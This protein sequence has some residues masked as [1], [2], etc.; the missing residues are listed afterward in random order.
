MTAEALN[1]ST[2]LNTRGLPSQ[3]RDAGVLQDQYAWDANGNVASI[4]DQQEGLTS[5]SMGYD[6]LDRLTSASGIWGTGSYG[7]DALDN[8]R[9]STVG[10]RTAVA[11]L[12]SANRLA[13]LTV[14]GVAQSYGYDANGN[15][16]ARGSQA[17]S[18]DIGNRLSSAP[19]KASYA[20]DGHGRRTWVAY[21]DGSWKLQVYGS[22]GRLLFTGHSSQGNTRHVYLGSRLIAEDNTL[23]GTSYSHTDALGSPVARTNSAG[24]VTSRTRYEPY[25]AT[26][27]G[28]NPTGIGFTGHVNDA[29]TGLVYMQQRYYEPVAGRFLSVDPVTTDASSGSHFNRYAYVN[30]NPYRYTDPTG[31]LPEVVEKLNEMVTGPYGK[32]A[33]Q[34]FSQGNYLAGAGYTLAGAAFGAGNV[35]TLGQGAAA[36]KLGT[37]AT[38]KLGESAV[39]GKLTGD[40]TRA[41]VKQIQGVVNEAGRPLE[42]VGSAAAGTRRGVGSDLPIGKGPGTRSDID[43]VVAPSSAKHFEGLQGKLPGID[44]KTGVIPGLGNTNIGPVIRFEPK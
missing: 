40:L 33:D 30:N 36:V 9:T 29:D 24:Q 10:G 32:L 31:E 3:W 43:Y 37:T 26:A 44:P 39:A 5:R 18:F 20:Y 17:F 7:Y 1:H 6:A 19:G 12:D 25:G 28:T 22:S 41:E 34:A 4:A 15:L 13:G 2:S 38:V 16:T 21:A 27:A 8:L 42:V 14:N 23:T 35:L 11:T